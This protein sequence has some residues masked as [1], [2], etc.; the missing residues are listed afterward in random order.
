MA[1]KSMCASAKDCVAEPLTRHQ[2]YMI[3]TLSFGELEIAPGVFLMRF[4]P[5]EWA[6][7]SSEINQNS[8]W[9]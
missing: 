1:R 2:A 8:D 7:Y 3:R 5:S 6:G 4:S 9:Q